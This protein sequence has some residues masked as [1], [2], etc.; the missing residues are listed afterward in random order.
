M[1]GFNS[2]SELSVGFSPKWKGLVRKRLPREEYPLIFTAGNYPLDIPAPSQASTDRFSLNWTASPNLTFNGNVSY[3]RLRDRYTHY[4]QNSFGSDETVNWRPIDRLRVTA[5]YHQQ[6]VLNNFTPYY[7]LFGNV[8]YHNHDEG[9]RLDYELPKNFDVDVY[10]KRSGITRS[11]ATLWP[12]VFS[13]D[14]TDLLTVM[15]SS[16]SN[17][18]GMALRYH[19]RGYW[20]GR[21]GYEWTGTH[22]PGYLIVPQSNNRMFADVWLTPTKWLVFSNDTQRHSAERLSCHRTPRSDGTGLS[23]DFQRSDRFYFE[24]L[25][26]N[27]RFVPEWNLGLGYS[28]QQNN[29]TTYM[30]FQNDSGWAT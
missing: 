26:A 5:D 27:F 14:N 21:A 2:L 3:A 6:N 4:P 22:Q 15:P 17:T 8:S 11:N 30:G 7:S 13:F 28:Y 12:Q 1:T 20:S 24:T 18:T 25:S 10:Y 19:D 23:G 16:F 9:L 29:L